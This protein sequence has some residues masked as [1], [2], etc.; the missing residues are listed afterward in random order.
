MPRCRSSKTWWW[1]PVG[2]L[3]FGTGC[4]ARDSAFAEVEDADVASGLGD[5]DLDAIAGLRVPKMGQV[6]AAPKKVMLL[7]CNARRDELKETSMN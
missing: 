6:V 1:L 2:A 3:G 7:L 5:R 4:P